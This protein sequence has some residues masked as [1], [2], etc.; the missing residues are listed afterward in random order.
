MIFLPTVLDRS[1][2]DK[3]CKSAD[4]PSL[5]MARRLIREE[6]LLCGGSSGAAMDVAVG[7]A[8]EMKEGERIVVILPDG[9]RN[10]MTK[11][12]SDDWMKVREM[13][14]TK[15]NEVHWWWNNQVRNLEL[16]TPLT[17]CP[18]LT[19]Q[20]AVKIMNQEGFDQLPVVDE[21]GSVQ[22]VVT[23]GN[24]MSKLVANI[25]KPDDPVSKMLYKQF[26]MISLN[27]TLGKL[28]R[29][30]TNDHF[31][32]VVHE[33]KLWVKE[34]SVQTKSVVVGI[35]TSIDLL[36]YITDKLSVS[37]KNL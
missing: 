29:I 36:H 25:I 16:S 22:G 30:L 21:S 35:V 34:D 6:G 7:I 26:Q 9:V 37:E 24:L 15:E 2:V 4:K 5:L 10:Y 23:L 11:F 31:A 13:L 8:K 3:W 14:D 27:T 12:L 1:V 18:N 20:E 32:L 17:I 33:Q 28:S 19:C